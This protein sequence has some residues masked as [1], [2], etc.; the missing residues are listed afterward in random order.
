MK[1]NY[2]FII[3]IA[4]SKISSQ[5][6]GD[7]SFGTDESF[8]VMT[9]NIEWFPKNGQTTIDSV[10]TIIQSLEIDLYAFQE[11]SDTNL[12]KQMINDIDDYDYYFR[13]SWFGG[14]A[15]VFKT[16]V[17]EI[18]TIY[19]IYTEEQY[20]RPFPRSPMVMEMT[21]GDQEYYIINNH[22]KCCGN[23]VMDLSDPW[24]EE[25]R[26]YDASNLL[27]EYIDSYLF[28]ENVIVLGDLNDILTDSFENNVFQTILDDTQNFQFADYEIANGP[29]S[30]WSYPNWP[31]HIDHIFITN[32]LFDDVQNNNSMIQTIAID[33][34]I[35]GGFN[36]YDDIIS[37]HLP[38][39]LKL[40]NELDILTGIVVSQN[41]HLTHYPNPFN[42]KTSI[43]YQTGEPGNI[44]LSV[45]DISGKLIETLVNEKKAAG[46]YSIEWDASKVSTGL[47]FYKLS[48]GNKT[49]VNKMLLLK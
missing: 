22:F 7:L 47:Y 35:V 4:C 38:V 2:L 49:I 27:K 41:Y 30:G 31:S 14:L 8:E 1:N 39:A 19:E 6:L 33:D 45:Y 28:D 46:S 9:W 12:F 16:N 23:E 36:V 48:A 32:E 10:L 5:G 20:W 37:D 13:S 43:F 21:F 26:R 15:Y 3:I 34:Y 11:I 17:I 18:D 29:S 24:D 42:D 40:A 44:D 25:T